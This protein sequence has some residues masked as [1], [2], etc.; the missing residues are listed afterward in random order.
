MC[1]VQKLLHCLSLI[2]SLKSDLLLHSLFHNELIATQGWNK[3]YKH[4]KDAQGALMR[5]T[6]RQNL[7]IDLNLVAE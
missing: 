7:S 4:G 2:I 6:H 3:V 1:I 5:E